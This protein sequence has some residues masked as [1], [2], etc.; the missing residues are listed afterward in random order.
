[1]A[2]HHFISYSPSDGQD[3]AIQLCDALAAGPP[4]YTVWLDKRQL[5]PGSAW[6]EQIVEAIRTAESLL[7]V[8]TRDSVNSQSVC[9]QEWMRALKYNKPI[10][11]LLVHKDVEIPFLLESR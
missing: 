1:M 8:M 10:V 6:D 4:S 3:F 7:F 9:K 11:P 2:H 5:R